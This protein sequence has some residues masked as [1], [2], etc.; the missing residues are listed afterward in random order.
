MDEL[1]GDCAN[2][3]GLCCVA[4]PFARSADFAATKDAGTPCR[5]L[6]ADHR[7]GIHDQLRP[8]GYA[9]CTVYDC[10]GAGQRV[11]QTVFAGVDWR[12]AERQKMFAVFP[13]VRQLHE[14]LWYLAEARRLDSHDDL[15]HAFAEVEQHTVAS[16]DTIL[17]L[18]VA[19]VR[20]KVNVLLLRTSE[21]LR[22][23]AKS[24]RGADL[25]GARLRNKN[26]SS[27]DFRGAYLIGADL[28]NSDLSRADMIGADLRGADLSGADLSTCLFLTQPQVNAAQGNAKT[29]LPAA[30]SR[31]SHWTAAPAQRR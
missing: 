16:P 26:L 8:K 2:C 1:K 25:I 28:T 9:G 4:L 18:D 7:C 10:F 19:E 23:S 31:P 27:A 5:N 20:A 11:S 22:T 13:V 15:A 29:K 17:A 30:L 24:Y 21:R 12:V 14:L 6:L 3:F